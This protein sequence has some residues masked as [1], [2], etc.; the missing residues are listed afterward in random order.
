MARNYVKV[1]ELN[2]D[3]DRSSQP[4]DSTNRGD[5][6]KSVGALHRE[7]HRDKKKLK[8]KGAVESNEVDSELREIKI[9]PIFMH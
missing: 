1:Q 7:I 4:R 3:D 6:E 8:V 5:I 2:E 9:H